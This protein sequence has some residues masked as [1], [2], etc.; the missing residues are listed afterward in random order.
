[1]CCSNQTLSSRDWQCKRYHLLCTCGVLFDFQ[2][3]ETNIRSGVCWVH[4][5]NADHEM[6]SW[7]SCIPF[8][9]SSQLSADCQTC[10]NAAKSQEGNL[11]QTSQ[12][13]KCCISC[14]PPLLSSLLFHP[15]CCRGLVGTRWSSNGYNVCW[16][17]RRRRRRASSRP[18]LL[19]QWV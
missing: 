8:K 13:M 16:G 6:N 14:L 2:A 18:A 15:P 12:W 9:L 5:T 3:G 7:I 1:M 11:M 10:T 19:Q 17:R 4:A